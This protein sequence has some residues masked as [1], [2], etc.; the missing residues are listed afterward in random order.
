MLHLSDARP[1]IR[2]NLATGRV[3]ERITGRG[4]AVAS[5]ALSMQ[6]DAGPRLPLAARFLARAEGYFAFSILPERDMPDVSA[7]TNVALR[8]EFHLGPDAPI[9]TERT[10]AGSAF[11][12]EDTP[13]TIAG[14]QVILRTVAG[15]P[16]DLSVDTDPT[17]VALQGIVLRDHDPAQPV[18]QVQVAAGP[19]NALTDA[20][21]RFFLP[22]LPLLAE[23]VLDL[24]ENGTTT[25]APVPHRLRPTRQQRHPLAA[26][27][28]ARSR[29]RADP[30]PNILLPA[31]MSRKSP[32]APS[33]SKARARRRRRWSG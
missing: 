6:A 29:R 25:A 27:L 5:A 10:V 20:Q 19:T 33:R 22:A 4:L 12:L 21:G 31:S 7:A 30:C 2:Q 14:Q 15:A 13:R 16:I 24:T 1:A 18:A 32:P 26:Q 11:A 9:L 17:P 8:A 28:G 23:V 3:S